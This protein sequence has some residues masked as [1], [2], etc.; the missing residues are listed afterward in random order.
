MI[1]ADTSAWIEFFQNPRSQTSEMVTRAILDEDLVMGD[2]V[3]V[4]L[5][6]GLKHP[7]QIKLVSAAIRLLP[8]RSLCSPTLA[9]EAATNYR[10]L[11]RRGITIRGT[12]D[13]IIATWCIENGAY[14]LHTDRDFDAMEH[15]L[16]LRVWR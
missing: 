15:E 7:S 12:I 4:E 6:Q 14:L 3:I 11:R 8:T 1:L 9:Y 16:G 5:L 13:V 2:L 10:A